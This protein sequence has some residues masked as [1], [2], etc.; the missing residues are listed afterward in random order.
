MGLDGDRIGDGEDEDETGWKG[1]RVRWE[2]SAQGWGGAETE[3][4]KKE[5][6]PSSLSFFR[7]FQ[8]Q[9]HLRG[10]KV[11]KMRQPSHPLAKNF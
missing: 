9:H 6:K 8:I 10:E 11:D 4:Q 1:F 7:T 2:G 5:V 3:L